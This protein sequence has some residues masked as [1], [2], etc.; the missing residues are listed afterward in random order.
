MPNHGIQSSSP[1]PGAQEQQ[2]FPVPIR[3]RNC[4]HYTVAHVYKYVR[5]A[6]SVQ[7][8]QLVIR[9]TVITPLYM[10]TRRK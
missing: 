9:R 8:S 6:D 3:C 1:L 5:L 2:A 7:R 4:D 10:N